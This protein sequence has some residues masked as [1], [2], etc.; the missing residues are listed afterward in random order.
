MEEGGG[1]AR[2][3]EEKEGAERAI[4]TIST[5]AHS[6][7]SVALN[8]HDELVLMACTMTIDGEFSKSMY[9]A[10]YWEIFY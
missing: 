3:R 10:V 5:T 1:G 7:E 2:E 9:S 4:I 6:V 8:V